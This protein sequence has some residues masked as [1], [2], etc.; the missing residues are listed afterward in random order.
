MPRLLKQSLELTRDILRGV[1]QTIW[2]GAEGAEKVSKIV[3]NSLTG[4]DA[5]IGTSWALEDL[6]CQDYVCCALDIIGSTSSAV[7]LVLGNIPQTKKYTTVT[8]S[9]TGGCRVVRLYCKNYGTFWGCTTAAG[10]GI[11]TGAKIIIK[12]KK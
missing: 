9:I 6:Q 11:V 2:G 5:I 12:N 10:Q 3:K 1:N 8:A 4:S 7:G